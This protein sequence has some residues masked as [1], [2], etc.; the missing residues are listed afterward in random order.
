M[1]EELTWRIWT[2]LCFSYYCVAFLFS[3]IILKWRLRWDSLKL[4]ACG[5]VSLRCRI[6]HNVWAWIAHPIYHIRVNQALLVFLRSSRLTSGK[7]RSRVECEL[8]AWGWICIHSLVSVRSQDNYLWA[9]FLSWNS[10]SMA[11]GFPNGKFKSAFYFWPKLVIGLRGRLA[12][13]L[14]LLKAQCSP[15][16]GGWAFE[17]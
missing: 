4:G 9:E 14:E 3:A 10:S 15:V 6:S 12:W 16:V 11:L 7:I 2:V 1:V 13:D 5:R 8:K 17:F